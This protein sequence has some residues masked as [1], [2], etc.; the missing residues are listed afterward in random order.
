[1]FNDFIMAP[2]KVDAIGKL[3]TSKLSLRVGTPL[4]FNLGHKI[5]FTKMVHILDHAP[6]LS[7][8][9][10]KTVPG[11]APQAWLSRCS[12]PRIESLRIGILGGY[13]HDH[14]SPAAR[15]VVALAV[16]M[17]GGDRRSHLIAAP[18]RE[19]LVF[20][21]ARALESAGVA[22]VKTPNL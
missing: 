4:A 9:L 2:F 5:G 22:H 8:P 20:R 3:K 13:F 18:W 6:A 7:E 16:T 11:L 21:A 14:A 1:L 15:E 12:T 10:S 19:D 17:L